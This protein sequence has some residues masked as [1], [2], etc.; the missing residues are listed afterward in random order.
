LHSAADDHDPRRPERERARTMRITSLRPPGAGALFVSHSTSE[1]TPF[2]IDLMRQF[3]LVL[4]R[5]DMIERRLDA[6]TGS[7]QE[8][9]S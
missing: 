8:R 2:E 5:L 7:K 6:L 4:Q 9:A 3:I 1:L